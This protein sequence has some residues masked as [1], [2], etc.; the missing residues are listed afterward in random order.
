MNS[1]VGL[2]IGMSRIFEENGKSVSVTLVEAGP[3]EITQ[4]K[5]KEKDGYDAIQVGFIKIEKQKNIKKPQANKP[6]KWLREFAVS[7][8][9]AKSMKVG[10]KIDITSFN[11]GDIVK[12]SG[13]SKGKGFQ[14]PMKRHGFHGR[15]SVSHGTKHELRTPGSTGS[16]VPEHIVKGK[17]MAGHMG[18]DRVSVKNLKIVKID[19]EN[20]LLA[21]GGAL[22]GRRGT[23]LEIIG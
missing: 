21:I 11:E 8:E 3:C 1:I 4:V 15:H 14:G 9:E 2:K 10:D 12:V 13:I 23:L 19:K 18:T 20:N 7:P 6:F 17:R 22:P 16:S 5:T